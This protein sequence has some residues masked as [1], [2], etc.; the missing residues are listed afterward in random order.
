VRRSTSVVLATGNAGKVR[1]FNRLLAGVFEVRPLPEGIGLPP[2]TADTF[3]ANARL[4]AE[5]VFQALG[6][7][8]AV[9][10]DDSGLEVAALGGR[11]GIFS[12]RFAGENASDADNV[13]KLLRELSAVSDRSARF[14]CALCLLV[15]RA[16][17]RRAMEV[18]GVTNGFI[19]LAPRGEDGFGYDPVFQPE[20]WD[21]TLAEASPEDKDRVSHRG[22][23]ARLLLDC[24]ARGGE[25]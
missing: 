8:Q 19:T 16:E 2:E 10:A 25:V 18:R 21:L 20:G 11:P 5:S 3:A 4:K 7:D 13:A 24:L 12:A 9:L 23:A 6:G 17:S 1:E 14:V 22:A 15:P